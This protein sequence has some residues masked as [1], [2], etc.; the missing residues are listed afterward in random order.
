MKGGV[1]IKDGKAKLPQSPG[2]GVEL[3]DDLVEAIR[4]K[5]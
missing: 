2:L 5:K 3:V 1:V 4:I